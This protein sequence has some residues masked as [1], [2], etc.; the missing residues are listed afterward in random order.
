[1]REGLAIVWYSLRDLWD[2]FVLL[3][4]LNLVWALTG[5]IPLAP[6]FLLQDLGRALGLGLIL[7]IPFFVVSGALCFV[8]NQITRGAFAGWGTFFTGI[9]RY[10]SK[11]LVVGLVNLIVVVL[12]AANFQ[13]YA[14]IMEGGWTVFALAGWV[15]VALYWLLVQLYW[16]PMMFSK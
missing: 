10:W 14:V 2:Q 16:F 9:R 7:T 6:F 12:L 5:A 1:M 3:A 8:A 13:F 15:V 11:S 4:V